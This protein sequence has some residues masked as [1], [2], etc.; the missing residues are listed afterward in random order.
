MIDTF[1]VIVILVGG[2]VV[3]FMMGWVVRD[4]RGR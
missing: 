2:Y 4:S 1:S 3:G